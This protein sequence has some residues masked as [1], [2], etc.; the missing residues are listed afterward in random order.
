M[1]DSLELSSVS[2]TQASLCRVLPYDGL[3]LCCRW[4]ERDASNPQALSY[5]NVLRFRRLV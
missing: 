5:P 1:S 2:G 4:L 3:Q